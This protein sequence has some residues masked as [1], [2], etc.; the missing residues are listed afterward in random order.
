M[1]KYYKQLTLLLLFIGSIS[2]IV[3]YFTI[4]IATLRQLSAFRPWS[5]MLAFIFLVL[6]MYFD[7]TRLVKLAE[8]AGEYLTFFQAMQVIFSNYFLALLTPGATGGA[9]AQVLFLRHAGVSTGK[10]TVL[11]LVRTILS[12][13]FLIV[14]LPLVVYLEPALIPWLSPQV[15]V[16]TAMA[17]VTLSIGGMWLIRTSWLNRPLLVLAGRF[18]PSMRRRGW[19]MYRDVQASVN[20]LISSPFGMTKVFIDTGLSLLALYSIVPA[21]FMGL[22]IPINWPV[23]LGRMIFLNLLLYFAPTPGGAGIA[24]GGFV[25]LFSDFVPPGTVGILAVGWRILAEYLPFVVGLYV[26][27]KAF[28]SKL[29]NR[30]NDT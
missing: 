24:E 19:K 11:V 5:I 7:G 30:S 10:A 8:M 2:F 16:F 13:L 29:L 21:L 17:L 18:N 12:I 20:M 6:G 1:S 14:S 15:M 25:F 3:V 26:S 27:T 9:V 22:D 23:V 28:G 4:D